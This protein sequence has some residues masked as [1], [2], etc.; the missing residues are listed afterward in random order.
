M[1]FIPSSVLS[2]LYNRTSLK[3]A[4]SG[5]RFSVKNR[6]S[7]ATLRKVTRFEVDSQPVEL[8]RIAVSREGDA[9]FPVA[10][11]TAKKPVDF[12]LGAHLTFS[13]DMPPLEEGRHQLTVVFDT[14]PFG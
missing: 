14:Q 3:N 13:L 6:L 10:Q 8:E 11:I 1:S 12:P 9:P 7:P 4:D 2:K 5:V